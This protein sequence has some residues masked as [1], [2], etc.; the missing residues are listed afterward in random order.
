MPNSGHSGRD[1]KGDC[2]V[3]VIPQAQ[4]G[5]RLVLAAGSPTISAEQAALVRETVADLGMAH[6]TIRLE[7]HGAPSFALCA[8]VETAARRAGA[9]RK[10]S[11]IPEQLPVRPHSAADRLRRS[12]LYVPGDDPRKIVKATTLNADSVILDLE[13]A[14]APGEKDAARIMVRR[15]LQNL[16]F[17]RSERIVR[18]NPLVAGGTADLAAILPAG[19]DGILLPKCHTAADLQTLLQHL[20]PLEKSSGLSW[21]PHLLAMIESAQGVLR[22]AR[23]AAQPRVVAIIFGA[24]DFTADMGL[25]HAQTGQALSV[26]RQ[27]F[28]LAA[29]ANRV[30]AIDMV[31]T[32]IHDLDGFYRD[33]QES[34]AAGFDGRQLI[35]PPQIEVLHRAFA[36][37]PALIA[38]AKRIVEAAMAGAADGRGAVVVDTKM[39]DAPVVARAHRILRLAELAQPDRRQDE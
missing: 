25:L 22:A 31:Y 2:C 19:P 5:L 9:H 28:L 33:T 6:A 16:D 14:V 10:P 26:P 32:D 24:E 35:Y 23:I 15:A 30:Q 11:S 34:V 36:P 3:T 20:K 1:R 17:G 38:E 8:R 18:I 12:L 7:D 27:L 21:S 37:P 4:G 29:K 13:D 39:V